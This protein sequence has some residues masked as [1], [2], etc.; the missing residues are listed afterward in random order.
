[1]ENIKP[2]DPLFGFGQ[3]NGKISSNNFDRP[4][5]TAKSTKLAY[6]M[7]FFNLV[8]NLF[9]WE[10]LPFSANSDFIER[11]LCMQ[12]KCAFVNDPDNGLM[13]PQYTPTKIN[14]YSEPTSIECYAYDYNREFNNN[15]DFVIIKNSSNFTPTYNYI[16]YFVERI[17][18]LQEIYDININAQKTPVVFKGTREQRELLKEE[19]KKY[20]G[21]AWYMFLEKDALGGIEALNTNA[22]YLGDK[23]NE[24]IRYY[25]DEFL[26]FIGINNQNGS[27]KKER[28]IVDEINANNEMISITCYSML[29]ARQQACDE[30]NTKFGHLLEKPIEVNFISPI[31]NRGDCYE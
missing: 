3:T 18:A 28:N 15:D 8:T 23:I 9:E 27:F 30:I 5:R 1:M 4:I 31:S 24:A 7:Y 2:F 25:R 12:G 21:N 16:E 10:N 14:W 22:P 13:S 11:Q 19:F 26:T 29:K 6:L 17:I 20:D